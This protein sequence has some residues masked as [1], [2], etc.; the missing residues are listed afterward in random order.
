MRNR[1]RYTGVRHMLR[2]RAR[3]RLSSLAHHGKQGRHDR[4]V[5][6]S[7]KGWLYMSIQRWTSVLVWLIVGLTYTAILSLTR[8]RRDHVRE[9]MAVYVNPTMDERA[10]MAYTA[11]L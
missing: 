4:A 2:Y 9:R 8:I 5:S 10:G 6:V 11:I 7:E 3:S 1:S